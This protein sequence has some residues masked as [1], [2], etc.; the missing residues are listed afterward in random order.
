MNFKAIGFSAATAVVAT[1]IVLASA[2]AEA[3]IL[4]DSVL[5]I[6]GNARLQL[7][8]G[9]LWR[10]DFANFG[11]G[12]GSAGVEVGSTGSFAP[13]A[14]TNAQVRDLQL[15]RSGNTWTL[16]GTPV[17]W[18]LRLTNGVEY[19]L[20]TFTLTRT[21]GPFFTGNFFGTFFDPS[22]D[23]SIGG[24]GLF[25]SQGREFLSETGTTFS[26]NITVVPTPALLPGLLGL[27]IAAL[28]KRKRQEMA[29]K[30]EV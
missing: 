22:D 15:T 23:T 4:A 18:F 21:P 20:D 25:S 11:G 17:P 1:G 27:G 14:G 9:N 12:V 19:D 3:A 7:I 8:S 6:E 30:A 26:A 5:A 16:A 24:E 2:P 29:T 28:R 10:L 13:L